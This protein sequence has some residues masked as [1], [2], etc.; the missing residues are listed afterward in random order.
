[1]KTN[2]SSF[3]PMSPELLPKQRLNEV[4]GLPPRPEALETQI[5]WLEPLSENRPKRSPRKLVFICSVEWA[6]SPMH[7]RID[8]YYLNPKPQNWLLWNNWVND[9]AMPWLWHWELK[10]Y[11]NQMDADM[12]TI[13]AYM[14]MEAWKN[15]AEHHDLDRYHWINNTGCLSVEDVQSV[16]R[17]IW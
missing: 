7:N 2:H 16:A 12:R 13:A 10:A 4:V 1:M 15:E 5:D 14:L 11:A 3:I 17:E 9:H 8:N 6:W